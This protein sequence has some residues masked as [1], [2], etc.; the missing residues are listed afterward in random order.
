L[1]KLQKLLTEEEKSS[2]CI[3]ELRF[4]DKDDAEATFLMIWPNGLRKERLG[5]REVVA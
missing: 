3:G 4:R 5:G 1:I 2:I